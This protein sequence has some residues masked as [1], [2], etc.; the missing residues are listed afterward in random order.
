MLDKIMLFSAEEPLTKS[1][2]IVEVDA[3]SAGYSRSIGATD[4]TKI[5]AFGSAPSL[6]EIYTDATLL[7]TWIILSDWSYLR[8]GIV[9][10]TDREIRKDLSDGNEIWELFT[11]SDVGKE[12]TVYYNS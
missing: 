7:E 11:S 8:T 1:G 12:V 4:P 10:R 3:I 2:W 5:H 6:R 9:F